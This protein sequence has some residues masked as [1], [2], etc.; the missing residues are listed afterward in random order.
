MN[1][2]VTT[3]PVAEIKKPDGQNKEEGVETLD[4]WPAPGLVDSLLS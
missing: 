3:T 2:D 4:T 1:R